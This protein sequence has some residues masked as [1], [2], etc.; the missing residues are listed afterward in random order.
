MNTRGEEIRIT[1]V[2]RRPEGAPL[3]DSSRWGDAVLR[4]IQGELRR[5]GPPQP[6]RA[7]RL[8]EA[9]ARV[10]LVVGVICLVGAGICFLLAAR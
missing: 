8:R 9:I 6:S 2:V 10:C 7:E 4:G 5:T 3:V 1:V